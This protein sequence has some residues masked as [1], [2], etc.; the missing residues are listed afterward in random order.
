MVKAY[1]QDLRDR[2]IVAV[3]EEGMSCRGAA[4]RFG[5]GESSAIRWV[6]RRRRTGRRDP[7]GTGGHRPSKLKPHRE[8]LLQ[9]L[10]AE[11]DI[12]LTA[13]A[14]R[15]HSECG[16]KASASMLCRFFTFEGISFKKKRFAQRAGQAGCRAK[17]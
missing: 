2:V 10:D 7:V 15:F 3:E 4:K 9:A 17:A 5:I 13:L 16:I 14:E 12:T 8:W 6:D 11:P 1:S